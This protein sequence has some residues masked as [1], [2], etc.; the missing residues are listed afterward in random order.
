MVNGSQGKA[1]IELPPLTDDEHPLATEL[2]KAGYRPGRFEVGGYGVWIGERRDDD[3]F[4]IPGPFAR[5]RR[6]GVT[7]SGTDILRHGERL[8]INSRPAQ[9]IDRRHLKPVPRK[10]C[11]GPRG[12]HRDSTESLESILQE[13]YNLEAA[14]VLGFSMFMGRAFPPP[15]FDDVPLGHVE[16]AG[17]Q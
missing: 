8:E 6:Y 7:T 13:K 14:A 1:G 5:G 3:R 4:F 9:A 17:L 2:V 16:V 15:G 10:H 12:Q 11:G